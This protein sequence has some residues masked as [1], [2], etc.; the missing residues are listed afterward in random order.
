MNER[1]RDAYYLGLAAAAAVQATCPRRKVG[2]VVIATDRRMAAGFNG[3]PAGADECT[4]VGCYLVNDH[5]MRT[6]HAEVN[7]ILILGSLAKEATLYSTTK[8][9]FECSKVIINARIARV[10]WINS[11]YADHRGDEWLRADLMLLD[12]GVETFGYRA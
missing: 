12:A 1:E 6:V 5:C 3:A 8:P 4:D 10:V 7:A 2:A 9:C 11:D